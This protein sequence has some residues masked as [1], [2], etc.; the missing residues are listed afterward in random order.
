MNENS[1][2]INE[3]SNFEDKSN[4]RFKG[5][6]SGLDELEKRIK[7]AYIA[8]LIEAG[9]MACQ[10]AIKN[11]DYEDVTGNLRSS[12]CYVI[13]YDGRIIKEG[14]FHKVQGHG[15]N[16][17]K[18]EFTTKDGKNVSFWAKGKFGDGLEGNRRGLEFARSKVGNTGYSFI[19]V[20]GMKYASF[21][22]SK[23]YDVLDSGTLMLWKLIK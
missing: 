1:S 14:G 4:M 18:V 23:G 2:W 22:S 12:L 7:M 9:E 15:A 6:T 19:L 10:E 11:G 16:M 3:Y 20:A 21:V 13:A 8:R 17:Q 5:D